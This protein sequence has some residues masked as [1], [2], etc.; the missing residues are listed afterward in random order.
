M[1]H[2]LSKLCRKNVLNSGRCIHSLSEALSGGCLKKKYDAI[3]VGAGA[4]SQK[5]VTVNIQ[6]TFQ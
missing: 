5:L 6:N 3:V 2:L 1:F 4:F